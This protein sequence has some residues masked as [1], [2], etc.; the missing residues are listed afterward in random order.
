MRARSHGVAN[1]AGLIV[2]L[3]LSVSSSAQ[4]LASG[5]IACRNTGIIPVSART[6]NWVTGI[7][8]TEGQTISLQVKA[9]PDNRPQTWGVIDPPKRGQQ[10]A[11]GNEIVARGHFMVNNI[12]H[13]GA[14]L[15]R[16]NG[17]PPQAFAQA[18]PSDGNT[19]VITFSGRGNVDFV[20]NDEGPNDTH[21]IPIGRGPIRAGWG[22]N[23]GQLNVSFVLE[24]CPRPSPVPPA[25]PVSPGKTPPTAQQVTITALNNSA[26]TV[27]AFYATRKAASATIRCEELRGGAAVAAKAQWRVTIAPDDVVWVR[28]ME[29]STE[30]CDSRYEKGYFWAAGR[31][32]NQVFSIY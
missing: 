15:I 1:V 24:G 22:D 13:E 28:L 29:S 18:S 5:A 19:R 14:L 20:A 26:R 9:L 30:H 25:N 6:D 10:A 12:A 2:G 3:G 23:V 11:W 8:L 32:G 16:H 31:Q 4:E 17:G 7:A 21:P 27:Y